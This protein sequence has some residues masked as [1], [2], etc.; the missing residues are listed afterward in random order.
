[1]VERNGAALIRFD[2]IIG[3]QT[4]LS[5]VIWFAADLCVWQM[6]DAGFSVLTDLAGVFLSLRFWKVLILA[7]RLTLVMVPFRS[8]SFRLPI[9]V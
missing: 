8:D 2:I 9:Y 5:M 1:M 4:S 6:A 3:A 7:E